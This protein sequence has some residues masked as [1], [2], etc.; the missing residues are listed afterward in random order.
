MNTKD[1]IF[2]VSRTVRTAGAN[3]TKQSAIYKTPLL[4]EIGASGKIIRN[5]IR[6]IVRDYSGSWYMC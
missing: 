3:W 6:G 5:D 2:A 1:Q 4:H